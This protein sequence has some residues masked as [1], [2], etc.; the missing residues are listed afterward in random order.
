MGGQALQLCS[1]A[2]ADQPCGAGSTSSSLRLWGPRRCPT[3]EP[4]CTVPASVPGSVRGRLSRCALGITWPACGPSAAGAMSSSLPPET[5]RLCL[6]ETQM[7][8]MS[9]AQSVTVSELGVACRR[10]G[11]RKWTTSCPPSPWRSWSALHP[12]Q[13]PC[14]AQQQGLQSCQEQATPCRQPQPSQPPRSH[15]P[16]QSQ[17]PRTP[18][19]RPLHM[20]QVSG[21]WWHG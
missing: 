20:C 12:G 19:S 9:E 1:M 6:R 2:T 11:S 14:P 17:S 16:S 10:C 4:S 21:T 18:S 15:R 5:A 13:H 7:V 8:T 3:W